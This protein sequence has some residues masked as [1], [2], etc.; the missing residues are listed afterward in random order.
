MVLF[1]GAGAFG[2]QGGFE[3]AGAECAPIAG[4][5]LIDEHGLVRVD[6]R[7][8]F[9][10]GGADLVILDVVLVRQDDDTSGHAMLQSVHGGALLACLRNRAAA[11]LSVAAVGCDLT[12]GCHK[13][14]GAEA[15]GGYSTRS[16]NAR[17][18]SGRSVNV[19]R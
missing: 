17:A 4:G 10:Q 8:A 16:S 15:R 6:G 3:A 7:I 13:F 1:V 11:L 14:A 18:D 5:N 2:Q 12:C 19:S 9:Q